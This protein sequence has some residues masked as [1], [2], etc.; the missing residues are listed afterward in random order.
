[1]AQPPLSPPPGTEPDKFS[2]GNTCQRAKVSVTLYANVHVIQYDFTY[3]LSRK[4]LK[5]D[6]HTHEIYTEETNQYCLILSCYQNLTTV[7]AT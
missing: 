3:L 6:L 2:L 1:M 5:F 7:L 4:Q